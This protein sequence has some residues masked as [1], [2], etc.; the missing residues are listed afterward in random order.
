MFT[1]VA[2]LYTQYAKGDRHVWD[3]PPDRRT[4]LV[5]F[6]WLGEF[7]FLVCG[8]CTKVSILL[9]YRRLVS[10]V[11]PLRNSDL[12][13]HIHTIPQNGRRSLDL[14]CRGNA[15]Q[16]LLRPGYVAGILLSNFEPCL[17]NDFKAS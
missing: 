13:W 6:M 7:S 17:L 2:I 14:Q 15:S 3:T 12:R 1:A 9:F 10:G 16:I 11:P 4:D 5:L 8:G